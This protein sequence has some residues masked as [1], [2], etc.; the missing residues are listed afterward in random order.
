MAA[1]LLVRSGQAPETA[2]DIPVIRTLAEL[3]TLLA[4]AYGEFP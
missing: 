2:G 4:E 1:V 3:P